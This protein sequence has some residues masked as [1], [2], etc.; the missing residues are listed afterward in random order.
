MDTQISNK[1]TV[2]KKFSD[3]IATTQQILSILSSNV[4]NNLLNLSPS[5]PVNNVGPL[6]VII[7]S[8]YSKDNLP[9]INL[10]TVEK[11]LTKLFLG[12]QTISPAGLN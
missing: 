12:V 2:S 3:S 8:T 9:K 6:V 10:V 7:T 5:F 1:K 11:C 4:Q